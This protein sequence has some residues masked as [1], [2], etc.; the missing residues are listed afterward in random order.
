MKR[1]TVVLLTGLAC[2]AMP[3]AAEAQE[4]GVAGVDV[5]QFQ[6]GELTLS[7][8]AGFGVGFSIAL[9]PGVEYPLA[10]VQITDAFPLS[11]GVAA[12][13]LLNFFSGG[14]A[15]GLGGFGTVH[16]AFRT[17]DMD[18]NALDPVDVYLGIGLV[19]NSVDYS[20][21]EFDPRDGLGFATIGG[22]SYFINDSLAFFLEGNYW[23]WYGGATIGVLYQL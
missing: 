20:G 22:I 1:W 3:L 15:F 11:F 8:G 19:F 23:S 4:A 9:Y 12:R 21:T 10:Q 17:L 18:T 2:L 14:T 7:A 6:T 5:P 13:G 16:F